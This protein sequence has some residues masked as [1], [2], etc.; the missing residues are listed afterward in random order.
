MKKIY[1][2][3]LLAFALLLV[4]C[5]SQQTPTLPNDEFGTVEPEELAPILPKD[6]LEDK[7]K[8]D[9]EAILPSD[10]GE[11]DDPVILPTDFDN[12][13]LF[14]GDGAG[15]NHYKV[16][17]TI[18]S[19]YDSTGWVRT[20]SLSGT[21]D[22]AAAATALGYGVKVQNG[23]IG[24]DTPNLSEI[25]IANGFTVGIATTDSVYGATPSG[26]SA[27]ASNRN[28][29]Q[30]IIDA[31]IRSDISFFI[32]RPGSIIVN[33][34]RFK[35]IDGITLLQSMVMAL[36]LLADS[37][38][39]FLVAE[40]AKIDTYSHSN[41]LTGAIRHMQDFY[42]AINYVLNRVGENTLVIIASDHETGGLQIDGTFTTGGHTN[43][44]IPIYIYGWKTV[45][46]DIHHIDVFAMIRKLIESGGC[47]P[48]A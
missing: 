20:D 13:V 40:G 27:R 21:T 33:D 14:I 18:L 19:G 32:S 23:I 10:E 39:F 12:I 34:P 22:S 48:T 28:N 46:G 24:A 38:N 7:S 9:N 44:N 6:D 43:Q 30:E 1:F 29:S 41:D 5:Q 47:L 11:A 31:Q 16:A 17:N 2:I 8:R 42:A 3:V 36:D 37:S 35:Q 26:F 45:I 15:I 25:A 4:S